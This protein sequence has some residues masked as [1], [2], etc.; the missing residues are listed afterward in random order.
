[1]PPD[2]EIMCPHCQSKDVEPFKD[3]WKC[4]SCGQTFTEAMGRDNDEVL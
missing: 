3:M 1:M 4:N 2:I